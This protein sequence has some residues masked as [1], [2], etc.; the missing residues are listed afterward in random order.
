M[1]IVGMTY[2]S[3]KKRRLIANAN[4]FIFN[5]CIRLVHDSHNLVS[6]KTIS[7][8]KIANIVLFSGDP[9]YLLPKILSH[10]AV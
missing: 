5:S 4:S 9:K 3:G 7:R 2:L 6:L 10:S 1:L 8:E